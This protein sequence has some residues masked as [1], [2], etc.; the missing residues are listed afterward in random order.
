M[1]T[2]QGRENKKR[3]EQLNE[4]VMYVSVVI[5]RVDQSVW[6]G[7]RALGILDEKQ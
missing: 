1:K 5:N 7:D 2:K 3:K 6:V 4:L